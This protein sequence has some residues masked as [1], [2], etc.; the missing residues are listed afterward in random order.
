MKASNGGTSHSTV[1]RSRP[2]TIK[3]ASHEVK[4]YQNISLSGGVEGQRTPFFGAVKYTL[5]DGGQDA[6]VCVLGSYNCRSLGGSSWTHTTDTTSILAAR[7]G[8]QTSL[9]TVA[10]EK[11]ACEQLMTTV[12]E[13][14]VMPW[15]A[16][17]ALDQTDLA[18]MLAMVKFGESYLRHL[19]KQA[20]QNQCA[21]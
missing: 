17:I 4:F 14:V 15:E 11:K 13:D 19:Y 7:G 12:C 18:Q 8:S 2:E 21:S 20:R 6:V 5:K 9:L 1:Q 16:F 3:L 10:P